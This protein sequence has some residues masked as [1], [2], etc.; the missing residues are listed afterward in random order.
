MAAV[1]ERFAQRLASND[2]PVRNRALK[3]L[4]KWIEARSA[5]ED[6]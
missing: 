4:N 5:L 3:R 6:G 1:E 2:L